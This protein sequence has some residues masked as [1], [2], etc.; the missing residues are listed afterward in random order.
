MQEKF[1][2]QERRSRL[3]KWQHFTKC[4]LERTSTHLA[5]S[6]NCIFQR[7]VEPYCYS[8]PRLSS[9]A[10]FYYD[11]PQA[12]IKME[13]VAENTVVIL[14]VAPPPHPLSAP[15]PVLSLWKDM[16]EPGKDWRIQTGGA[17][18]HHS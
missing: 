2:I 8:C 1:Q 14:N 5:Q 16:L 7:Q 6:R 17:R 9:A 3:L 11:F 12:K 15:G 13:G 10:G 4:T 18:G